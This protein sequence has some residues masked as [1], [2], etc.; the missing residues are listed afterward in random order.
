MRGQQPYHPALRDHALSR[1]RARGGDG[2][3]GQ[4][5]QGYVNATWTYVPAAAPGAT[6]S[7]Q[8]TPNGQWGG[9]GGVGRGNGYGGAIACRGGS[10]PTIIDCTI[11]DN[12]AQGGIGGLGGTGGNAQTPDGGTTW[13]GSQSHGGAGGAA[14]GDGIGGGIFA[15]GGSRPVVF[16]CRFINNVAV[17]A[18]GGSGGPVGQG[19]DL[20]A[21]L[22]PARV[23][24]AGQGY[25]TGGIIGGAASFDKGCAARFVDCAFLQN[26]AW[27][28]L[29]LSTTS[30]G[31]AIAARLDSR[32]GAIYCGLGNGVTL[33]GC[34]FEGNRGGAVFVEGD[35][36]VDVNDCRFTH[37][38]HVG[39]QEPNELKFFDSFFGNGLDYAN[40]WAYLFYV[41]QASAGWVPQ[42]V[43]G[44]M[45]V[46][47]DCSSVSLGGCE[48]YGNLTTSHGG[49][50]GL[51]SDANMVA[52]RFGDNEAADNGGAVYAVSSTSGTDTSA[53]R[54]LR[55]HLDRCVFA[56][57]LAGKFIANSGAATL[58]YA[59]G[60]MGFA[61]GPMFSNAH[62]LGGGLD[63]V[64][65]DV[66]FNDCTLTGNVAKSGGAMYL[67]EGKLLLSGGIVQGNHA[68]GGSGIDTSVG[69]D[70]LGRF[71]V[72]RSADVGTGTDL[73]GA[74][75]LRGQRGSH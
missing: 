19:N 2:A 33:Q 32:G 8:R 72:S 53:K 66:V 13:S 23:G 30:A 1:G 42:Q 20:A 9:T 73:G 11:K 49:A 41:Y 36:A 70:L 28:Q 64:A 37:N 3:S 17:T 5:F 29:V 15:D 35:S 57:N 61:V 67:T 68:L 4:W 21:P 45:Q 47:P 74:L 51:A 44:G 16:N 48:F 71:G 60:T 14:Y 46:G 63:L 43:A 26:K 59:F 38:E 10:G 6:P 75:D 24:S 55:L 58:A 54:L 62:G 56:E 69:F 39:Y 34:T 25:D 52:C 31:D 65:V 18:K 7:L 12:V 50:V 27:N 40:Y 22:G